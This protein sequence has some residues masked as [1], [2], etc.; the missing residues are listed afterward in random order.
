MAMTGG[1][2]NTVEKT[3]F[4][5]WVDADACPAPV[6]EMLYRTARRLQ[7][8]VTLVA[9]QSMHV[10]SNRL[11]RLLTV[12]GG[13][14]VA[15]DKIVELLTPGDVVITGDIPLAARVVG[16]SAIAIGVRGEL[17]DDN[18]VHDRLAARDLM[19]QFRSAGAETRGPSSLT[20]KDLQA[21]ANVLDRTLTRC[22]KKV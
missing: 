9:N 22:L 15:D 17:F 11:V 5:I 4:Q 13:A 18:S 12:P 16:K 10:P 2:M 6:K 8:P 7:V 14:D 1:P 20:P 19:E 3:T 21:F